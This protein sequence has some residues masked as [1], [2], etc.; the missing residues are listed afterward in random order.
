LLVA[1]KDH[2]YRSEVGYGLEGSLPDSFVG[3]V[4]REF[5]VP[6]FRKGDY[7][8]GIYKAAQALIAKIAAAAGVDITGLP[9]SEGVGKPETGGSL[10]GTIVSLVVFILAAIAFIRN[11]R[12]FLLFFLFSSMSG[13]SRRW[14]GG[15]GFGGGFGSFGGG[16][17]GGFGGGGASGSW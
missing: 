14:D 4:G 16:G 3:S 17:G 8:D 10:V 2:K 12:A 11:P 15:S 13:R 1:V 9:R 5:L 7:A 6:Y